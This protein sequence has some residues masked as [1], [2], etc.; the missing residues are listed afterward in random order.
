MLVAV[1]SI[2]TLAA[3]APPQV[4]VGSDESS[5]NDALRQ[6]ASGAKTAGIDVSYYQGTINWPAVAD[7]NR[8]DKSFAFIRANDGTFSDSKF[9]QNWQGAFD[10]GLYR[11]AYTFFR[12]S[13]DPIA[14]AQLLLA[15]IGGTIGEQDL[16]PVLDLEV[17]DGM[18][19]ATVASRAAKWLAYVEHALGRK[20]IVYTGAGFESLIGNPAAFG[21]YP[22]WTAN[23]TT[24]CPTVPSAWSDWTFWQNRVAS[25]GSVSGIHQ[26]VDLDY[27][28]G[29]A[30][31]LAAYAGSGH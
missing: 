22:L 17:K 7:P 10:A 18:S 21:D 28:N 12:A 11:G 24:A 31:E 14:Q 20:P 4:G 29:N 6:C 1:L 30:A 23:W 9:T 13:E 25:Y 2:A 3:C 26:K 19:A 16:P 8:G 5:V 27:F 15:R